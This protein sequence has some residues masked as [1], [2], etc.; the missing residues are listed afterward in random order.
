MSVLDE[1]LRSL[2]PELRCPESQ[3]GKCFNNTERLVHD[4]CGAEYPMSGSVPRALSADSRT[5]GHAANF[6]IVGRKPQSAANGSP[7]TTIHQ[8][9]A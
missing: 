4:R 3:A 8:T 6:E 7:E 5:H 2:L 1:R 9:V